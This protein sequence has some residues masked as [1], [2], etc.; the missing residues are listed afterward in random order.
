M[1]REGASPLGL[2]IHIPFCKSKCRYCDFCSFPKTDLEL[3]KTY[4]RALCRE[5]EARA[6]PLPVDTVFFGGGT[7]TILPLPLVSGILSCL[8]ESFHILP[9][10]EISI[11]GNPA[12][13]R[14]EGLRELFSLGFN[15]LSLG[16]QSVHADELKALGR[17]HTFEQAEETYLA[18]RKAGFRNINLDLMF[19]IPLQTPGSLQK[20]LEKTIGLAPDHIS[21]YGLQIEEGTPFAK[22]KDT[23]SLPDEETER[24]MYQN[25]VKQLEEAGYHRYEISNFAK[26]GKESRHNLKYWTYRDYLGFG[27]AAHSFYDRCRSSNTRVLDDYLK[28]PAAAEDEKQKIST[29]EASQEYIMLAMRLEEGIRDSEFRN[30]FGYSFLSAYEKKILP[31]EKLGLIRKTEDGV[32]FTTEGFYVSNT[33]LSDWLDFER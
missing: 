21:L 5:I 30:L 25:S 33:V 22:K 16:V 15:R 11:E 14:E 8:K 32:A 9:D 12:T 26:E 29:R 24:S 18:A 19:G 27:L 13:I 28:N 6:L 17:I 20:T 2:Y 23:L 31:L 1:S 10:A 7:P 4:T 3:M